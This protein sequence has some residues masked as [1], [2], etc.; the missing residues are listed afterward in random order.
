M[1]AYRVYFYDIHTREELDAPGCKFRG[2]DF[3]GCSEAAIVEKSEG[4]VRYSDTRF[5]VEIK[6]GRKVRSVTAEDFPGRVVAVKQWWVPAPTQESPDPEPVVEWAVLVHRKQGFVGN[7]SPACNSAKKVKL[8]AAA[9]ELVPFDKIPDP[10]PEPPKPLKSFPKPFKSTKLNAVDFIIAKP[11]M[12]AEIK[13]SADA[14]PPKPKE[15]TEEDIQAVLQAVIHEEAT[16]KAAPAGLDRKALQTLRERGYVD[17]NDEST[18]EGKA[19]YVASGGALPTFSKRWWLP[20]RPY[21]VVDAINRMA[22]ATGSP[23]YAMA[24]AS[25]NYNGHMVMV[26]WNDFRG[27]WV[28]GYTWAG[29]NVIA[30]GYLKYALEAALKEYERGALGSCVHA[31]VRDAEEAEI[32]ESLGYQPW[33][34]KIEAEYNQTWMTELHNKVGEAMQYE[35]AGLAP[36]VGILANAKDLADYEAQKEAALAERRAKRAG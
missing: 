12:D 34:K 20:T 32:A 22:A 25:A 18:E 9:R 1:S 11:A 36:L 26:S 30:R 7:E 2:P 28:A 13:A 8:G 27:Y 29:W 16:Y 5:S 15:P 6:V 21:K 33:S 24:A 23:R 17:A 3:H 35:K 31:T 4:A 19:A 14:E 10:D